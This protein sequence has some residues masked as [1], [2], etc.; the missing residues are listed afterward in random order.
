LSLGNNTEFF[1][2]AL[3]GLKQDGRIL[4][5]LE[6]LE[7]YTRSDIPDD[8]IEPIITALMDV[9]D[10]FPEGDSGLF[11]TDTP[12]RLLRLFYQLSHRFKSHEKRF[13]ILKRAMEKSTRSLYTIVHEV[14]VQ[15]QQHA[16]YGLEEKP[17]P[18]EKLTVKAEQLEELEKL[19]CAKIEI[20]AKDGRL[21]RHRNLS[22][23][24]FSLKRWKQHD[25]ISSFV[26]NMI[27]NDDG[28]IDF[29]ASFLSKSRSLGMSDY[30]GKIYWRI[31]IKGIEEFVDLKDIEP[32]IR[33]ILSSPDS[34]ELDD[35]RKLAVK[36]FLDT[37][38]GKTEFPYERPRE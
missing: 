24:L 10:L 1:A 13:N 23:I 29:I 16:K 5:F 15:D 28:L 9:G 14:S 2:E 22:S 32:R 37:I 31:S 6:R 35:T 27:R 4:R 25:Q 11:R 34:D 12:M 19:A 30:V 18:E 36:T 33:K 26:S 8:N 20:W 38:N 21:K 3:L 7:D 17:L